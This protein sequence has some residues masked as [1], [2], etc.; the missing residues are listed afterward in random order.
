MGIL[1]YS[2]ILRKNLQ[3]LDA[4]EKTYAMAQS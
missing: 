3:A 2:K 4:P 1:N